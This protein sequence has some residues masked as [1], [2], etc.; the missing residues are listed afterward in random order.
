[1]LL[2]ME[3]ELNQFVLNCKPKVHCNHL[4][5]FPDSEVLRYAYAE[6]EESRGA[7]QVWKV[8]HVVL[9]LFVCLLL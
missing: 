6:L 4:F 3:V 7:I 8:K 5:A 1:M 2:L 9:V